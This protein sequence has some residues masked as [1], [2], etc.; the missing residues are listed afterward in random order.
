[1]DKLGNTPFVWE[2]L[3]IQMGESIFVPMKT[4]NEARHQALE[5][6]QEKLLEKYRRD[7]AE[8]MIEAEMKP[9]ES[10]SSTERSASNYV[11]Y[12]VEGA[13]PVY[14]SCETDEAAEILCREKGIQG[15]YLPYL[16]ME[17]YL[18]AGLSQGKEMYLSLPHITRGNPPE[19]YLDQ[20]QKWLKAR[21]DRS[22]GAEPGILQPSGRAWIF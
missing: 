2:G 12:G 1:M 16:L 22:S 6:L 20:I 18:Q 5:E 21:H 4:L 15:I 13:I 10:A 7:K 8:K 11:S 14:A 19:G 17:K 3:D 9:E